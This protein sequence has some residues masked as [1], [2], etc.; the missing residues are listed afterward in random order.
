MEALEHKQII[1]REIEEEQYDI[2]RRKLQFE[3]ELSLKKAE[4]MQKF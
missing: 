4:S 2:E 3:R 1:E